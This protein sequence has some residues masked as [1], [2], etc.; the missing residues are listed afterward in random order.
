MRIADEIRVTLTPP[1]AP[2]WPGF[3][4]PIPTPTSAYSKGRVLWNKRTE[5]D[6]K[7]AIGFFQ[8]AIDK[9]P[10]YALAYDG[11]ADCWVPLGWYGFVAPSEAFPRAR[12]GDRQGAE[13]RRLHWPKLT[14]LLPS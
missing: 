13:S 2:D 1:T 9:D 14:P 10:N 4:L 12:A 7:K 6:L 5:E 11:L 3:A 8:Q